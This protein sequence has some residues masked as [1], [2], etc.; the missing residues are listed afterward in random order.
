M[1]SLSRRL[2]EVQ[3]QPLH[4]VLGIGTITAADGRAR[5][6]MTVGA[7]SANPRGALHGG[8]I[9]ALCDVAAYAALLS[10]LADDEDAVTHD[11]HVSLLRPAQT[12]ER[13]QFSA[14]VLRRGRSLAFIDAQA[15]RG[16][17]VLASARVT[18][19][20]LHAN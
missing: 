19:S 20:L 1:G 11:L 6:D 15:L 10:L 17:T 3:A 9:Y 13:V 4:R 16:D 2:D 7:H 18:K 8:V 14:Q 12:G 5:F